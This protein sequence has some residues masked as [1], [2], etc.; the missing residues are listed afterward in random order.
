[1]IDSKAVLCWGER[2]GV[3][4]GEEESLEDLNRGTEE[5]DG[6]ISRSRIG[7]LARFQDRDNGGMFP[8]RGDI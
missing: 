7:W 8:Y 2:E 1:M 5:G 6:T 3:E 4:F